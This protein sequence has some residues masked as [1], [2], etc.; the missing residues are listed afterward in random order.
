MF[1]NKPRLLDL[2]TNPYDAELGQS[3]AQQRAMLCTG[4]L[5]RQLCGAFRLVFHPT[6]SVGIHTA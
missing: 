4:L 3:T 2:E 1:Y 6:A 5:L